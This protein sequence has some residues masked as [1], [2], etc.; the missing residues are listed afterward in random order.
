MGGATKDKNEKNVNNE[1]VII[2]N[3]KHRSRNRYTPKTG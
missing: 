2:N 1:K 3:K